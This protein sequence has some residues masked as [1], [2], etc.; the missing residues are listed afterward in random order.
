VFSKSRIIFRASISAAYKGSR[1]APQFNPGTTART[2]SNN[3]DPSD[4]VTLIAGETV[5][6]LSAGEYLI[7]EKSNSMVANV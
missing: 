7:W 6:A 5:I 2:R 3:V 4:V 1:L